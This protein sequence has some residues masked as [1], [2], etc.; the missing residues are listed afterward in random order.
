[1]S[2]TPV[3]V[4]GQFDLPALSAD[5][6]VVV[7][8]CRRELKEALNPRI[9]VFYLYLN[10][11]DMRWPRHDGPKDDSDGALIYP[12]AVHLLTLQNDLLRLRPARL[13]VC[14]HA[15]VSRSPA[16]AIAAVAMLHPGASDMEVLRHVKAAR[17][18]SSPNPLILNLADRLMR[19]KLETN[20]GA[21]WHAEESEL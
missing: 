5:T 11:H 21:F 8:L 13:H 17:P 3:T 14:C 4:S 10:M 1:M 6:R 19:R 2:L 18:H 16:L 7:A 15:G 12:D 20:C 9:G